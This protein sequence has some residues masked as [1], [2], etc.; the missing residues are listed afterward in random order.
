MTREQMELKIIQDYIPGGALTE[1]KKTL[2]R[3]SKEHSTKQNE[4]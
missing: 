2:D 4:E 3:A 1:E